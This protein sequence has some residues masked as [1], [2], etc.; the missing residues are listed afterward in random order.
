MLESMLKICIYTGI[1]AD[2]TLEDGRTTECEDSAILKQNSQF[3]IR[4]PRY[5]SIIGVGE[6]EQISNHS[7]NFFKALKQRLKLQQRASTWM[8]WRRIYMS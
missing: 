8:I 2:V 5:L 6:A 3:Q 1:N 4:L 7:N